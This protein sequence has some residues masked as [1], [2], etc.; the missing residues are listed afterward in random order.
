[1]RRYSLLLFLG[2][3]VFSSCPTEGG[4]DFSMAR[5]A[6]SDIPIDFMGMVHAGSRLNESADEYA[7]LDDLGVEWMLTDFSWNVI[8]PSDNDWKWD[9]FDDY[10]AGAEPHGKK[11]LAILDYDVK[12]IH[13]SSHN[14]ANDRFTDGVEH[15]YIA[16]NEVPYFCDY[17][18]ETVKH[19]KGKVDAWCIWNEPNLNPRFWRGTMEEFF[20]LT[21]EA[22]KAIREVDPEAFIIGGA[23]NI[24]ANE[25]WVRGLFTSGAMEQ[26]DAVAYHP[27]MTGAGPTA[28]VFKTFKKN[29][30]EYGFEDKIW[31]TEVGY[32]TYETP[33]RPSGRYGTDIHEDKMPETVMQTIVLLTANGAQRIFWYHLFDPSSQNNGDS[34]DWFGLIK[35]DFTWKKGAVAYQLAAKNIPGTTCKTPERYDVPNS[36][37]SYYFEGSDGKH[38]LVVWNNAGVA[39]KKVQ[40]YLPGTNQKV[41]NLESG[42]AT[43]IKTTSTYTLKS[44]DGVNHFIQFFTWENPN[45]SQAPRISAP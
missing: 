26:I 35:N 18:K 37:E 3:L 38:C 1:M 6:R 39:P 16:P 33:P 27:Y 36:I 21:T 42:E 20:Y 11:I 9:R 10:V 23:L 7:L 31:V 12:W 13:D 45:S 34:E 44:K 8:E 43:P 19:Y 41:Y 17:V 24:L 28:N 2:A 15:R 4:G 32:P 40:V 29:V 14:T 25:D 5:I 22:A 30:S